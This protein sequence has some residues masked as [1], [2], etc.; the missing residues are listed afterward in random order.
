M[1]PV[2]RSAGA[3]LLVLLG[4]CAVAPAEQPSACQLER[5]AESPMTMGEDGRASIPVTID[6]QE[7]RLIIDT[8]SGLSLL[9]QSAAETLGLPEIPAQHHAI[10]LFG[11]DSSHRYVLARNLVL[12]GAHMGLLPLFIAPNERFQHGVAGALGAEFLKRYDVELDFAN[13]VF[14]LFSPNDCAG[15]TVYW[16]KDGFARIPFTLDRDE[17]ITV[18]VRLDGRD[19]IAALDTGAEESVGSLEDIAHDFGVEDIDSMLKPGTGVRVYRYPFR[20]LTF[21]GVAVY[22]PD[23]V[24]YPNA[25][26]R[27]PKGARELFIGMTILRHLHLYIAYGERALYVTSADSH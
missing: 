9:S 25:V 22:N 14:R 7:V 16:T 18:P 26:S 24:L 27:L 8:G 1:I 19:M 2:L 20:L 6:G 3:A 11:G 4:T 12:G 5:V 23:I 10:E 13:G 21:E 15:H 17:H